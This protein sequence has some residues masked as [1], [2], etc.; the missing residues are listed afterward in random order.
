MPHVLPAEITETDVAVMLAALDGK[1]P[2]TD[3]EW[4]TACF[5]FDAPDIVVC[6]A[7][8]NRMYDAVTRRNIAEAIALLPRLHSRVARIRGSTD[9][10]GDIELWGMDV[11]GDEITLGYSFVAENA[12]TEYSFSKACHGGPL[13]PVT[14]VPE[15]RTDTAI[16]LAK[17]MHESREFSAMPILADALQDAGCECAAVLDHCRDTSHTHVRGCWVV[18]LVLGKE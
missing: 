16:A 2:Y 6:I 8:P 11:D 7:L 1:T 5:D 18:D 13:Q 17:Q 4:A 3:D 10:H 14:F 15:W 12:Q 9:T